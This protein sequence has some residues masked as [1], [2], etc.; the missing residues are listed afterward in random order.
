[1]SLL[2][3][4]GGVETLP[5]P[6]DIP[7]EELQP[8]FPP[9]SYSLGDLFRSATGSVSLARITR[10][11]NYRILAHVTTFWYPDREEHGY[12]LTPVFKC[13]ASPRVVTTHRWLAADALGRMREPS[14]NPDSLCSSQTKPFT[15]LSQRREM[16]VSHGRSDCS[17]MRIA[18]DRGTGMSCDRFT[19]TF[20]GLPKIVMEKLA[21]R[22]NVSPQNTYKTGQVYSDGILRVSHVVLQC[23][24][25][26]DEVY[27]AVFE[28]PQFVHWLCSSGLTS[29]IPPT[30]RRRPR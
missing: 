9:H 26:N 11:E 25:F 17:G 12:F 20:C 5:L 7:E 8:I 19:W 6:S 27:R 1:M 15:V 3:L 2:S 13:T 29:P 18:L 16:G 14:G 22:E 23:I 30:D 28:Q 24:G 10:P 21:D 4:E